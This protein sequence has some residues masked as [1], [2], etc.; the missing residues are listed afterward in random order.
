MEDLSG[1]KLIFGSLLV[2]NPLLIFA[3]AARFEDPSNSIY[4]RLVLEIILAFILVAI[5]KIQKNNAARFQW[6]YFFTSVLIYTLLLISD[7][8]ID[9]GFYSLFVPNV[10]TYLLLVNASFIGLRFRHSTLLNLVSLII[11]T[12]YSIMISNRGLHQEQLGYLIL[13]VIIVTILSYLFERNSRKIFIDNIFID[14]QKAIIQQKNSEL[15]Q[16]NELKN[17]LMS[18][19]SHDIKAPLNALQSLLTLK[20]QKLISEGDML[21]HFKKVG[22]SVTNTNQFVS[23]MILWIKTQMDGFKVAK[24]EFVIQ[25]MLEKTIGVSR[26]FAEQKKIAIL[27]KV[28]KSSVL[29]S[30]KEMFSIILRN[31]LTNAIKFSSRE[32]TVIIKEVIVDKSYQI[33]VVDFG[34][35]VPP[36]KIS[37]LFS[38][39]NSSSLGTNNEEG[40]GLGLPLSYSI[41]KELGGNLIYQPNEGRG[42]IFSLVF[43]R[44]EYARKPTESKLH[45][46]E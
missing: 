16:Q 7:F 28:N 37:K 35:G 29:H 46:Q 33:Q 1:P 22:E 45:L 18:I 44:S 25:D 19:L 23:N 5:I 21:K 27:N 6:V 3:D 20:D 43:N 39:G 4:V 11:Y 41:M 31:L 36:E 38:L 14:R 24:E 32:G 10:T 12:L 30:D 17:T 8:I 40:T 26:S 15:E 9:E 13:F 42:A 2:L 34:K